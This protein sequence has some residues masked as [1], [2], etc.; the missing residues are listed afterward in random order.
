MD[1]SKFLEDIQ[2]R[3]DTVLG[4]A[5][6]AD[7]RKNLRAMIAQ[8]FDRMELVTRQELDAQKR[9]VER[10]RAKLE[11]LEKKLAEL[12]QQRPGSGKP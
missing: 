9:I 11:E 2:R 4:T 10:A 3:V 12:V 7:V 5:P 8:Q 6:V 1:R